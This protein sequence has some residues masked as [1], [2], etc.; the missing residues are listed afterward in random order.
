MI[1]AAFGAYDG[2]EVCAPSIT[3]A[4]ATTGVAA[5]YIRVVVLA[6]AAAVKDDAVAGPLCKTALAG[7][8]T[9]VVVVSIPAQ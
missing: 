7:C 8:A 5:P 3:G 9:V 6:G 4:P 1:A 2:A